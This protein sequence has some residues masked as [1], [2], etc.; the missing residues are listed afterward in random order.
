MLCRAFSW[1]FRQKLGVTRKE[2]KSFC[3]SLA[4][5]DLHVHGIPQRCW[6][7]AVFHSRNLHLTSEYLVN[8]RDFPAF[9]PFFL[10]HLCFYPRPT[11][12]SSRLARNSSF[13]TD[14][15]V[16]LDCMITLTENNCSV[17]T[18]RQRSLSQLTKPN[19]TS[20]EVCPWSY[21]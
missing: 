19:Y 4:Q 21:V 8:L 2:L 12:S 5:E 7:L 20:S 6:Y 9:R 11:R 1:H 18:L 14:Q 15:S 17:T 10:P 16:A 13:A 3:T